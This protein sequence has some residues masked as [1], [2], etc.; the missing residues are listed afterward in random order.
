MPAVF[1]AAI[2]AAGVLP[3]ISF[4]QG[5]NRSCIR[6]I[7]IVV[8]DPFRQYH[9][10]AHLTAAGNHS[11]L[12]YWVRG[13]IM[14]RVSSFW[15]LLLILM[16]GAVL[17]A[18]DYSAHFV[19]AKP[20]MVNYVEGKPQLYSPMSARGKTLAARDQ[21]AGGDQLKT[22]PADRVELLLNP[23]SYLRIA[24]KAH[25]VD[26][27]SSFGSMQYTLYEGDAILESVVLDKKVNSLKISTPCGQLQVLGPGLYRFVVESPNQVVVSVRSGKL[28]WTKGNSKISLLKKGNRYILTPGENN[29]LQWAELDKKSKDAFDLWSQKRDQYLSAAVTGSSLERRSSVYSWYPASMGGGWLF[30]PEIGVFTFLPFS[31]FSTSP[32]GYR[33]TNSAPPGYSPVYGP[34]TQQGSSMQLGTSAGNGAGAASSANHPS[35]PAPSASPAPRGAPPASGSGSRPTIR[36]Q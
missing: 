12:K 14:R 16:P 28:I 11:E 2:P 29:N 32:Y 9:R 21:L 27:G 18:Q 17:F 23:G 34:S 31:P 6:A 19:S 33:Y 20:G 22:G 3:C 5:Y 1:K 4:E 36:S 13:E 26:N 8:L 7:A 35:P 15:S 25:V 10:Q 24:G 30:N